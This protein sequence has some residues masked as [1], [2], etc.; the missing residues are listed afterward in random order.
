MLGPFSFLHEGRTYSCEARDGVE[1]Q[2]WWWFT[3][4]SDGNRYA[5]FPAGS[6]DTRASVEQRIVEYYTNH[7]ARRAAPEQPHWAKR[8]KPAGPEKPKPAGAPGKPG[9][10]APA[11][12][13]P[14]AVA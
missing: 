8:G 6:K 7:L 3:V 1:G 4:S 10:A 14:A 13:A 12:P 9:L 11:R 5:P 2:V